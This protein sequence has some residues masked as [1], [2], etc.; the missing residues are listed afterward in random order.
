MYIYM[1]RKIT[2][3]DEAGSTASSG[4]SVTR[5]KLLVAGATTAAAAVAGCEGVTDQ[6]FEASPVTLSEDS[7]ERLQLQEVAA[8]AQTIERS[9]AGAEITIT[10]NVAVYSRA[11]WLVSEGGE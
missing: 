7:R 4:D 10:N 9:A 6:S 5:R 1:S 3:E 2:P 11:G 8:D